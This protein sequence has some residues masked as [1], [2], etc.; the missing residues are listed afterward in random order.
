MA[1]GFDDWRDYHCGVR[2]IDSKS[3]V[4]D[5]QCW[6]NVNAVSDQNDYLGWHVTIPRMGSMA[7]IQLV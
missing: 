1:V 5:T 7:W 2:S 3:I 6:K 4:L